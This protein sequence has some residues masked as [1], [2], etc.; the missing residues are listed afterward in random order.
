MIV[1]IGGGAAGFFSAINAAENYPHCRVL[2]FEKS[3]KL[4][5]KVRISGGGRCN[6]THAC[7]DNKLLVKNY[8]RGEKQLKGVFSRFAVKDTI[9]WFANRGVEFHEE[10]DGRM[11]P[12]NNSSETIVNCLTQEAQKKKVDIYCSH[13]LVRIEKRGAENFVL[14]F[15]NGLQY[16]CEAVVVTV[17][18]Q[19]K[20]AKY[21]FI[22]LLGHSI[23]EPIPS[24]FTINLTKNPVTGLM[25]LVAQTARIKI[26]GTNHTCTGPLLITHW[27]F[28]GPAVLRL[29]AFA[30]EHFH[31]CNYQSGILINWIN[32]HEEEVRQ[33]L[34]Q[35]AQERPRALPGNYPLFNLPRRLWEFLLR[36][37]EIMDEKPWAEISKKQLHKL[38]SLLTADEYHMDGKTTFKEEFVTCGGVPLHEVDMRTMQS[39]ICPGLFFAG[40]VLDID[41]I[42]G[43]FNFQAA[44]STA[45][46]AAKNLY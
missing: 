38:I 17:G 8:P 22:R 4:L 39:K 23:K 34:L 3:N 37:A 11:F 26:A 10:E 44:W 33:A 13:E 20:V 14:H 36:K 28:S 24:L 27:G 32:Q 45:W 21:D 6:V 2:L 5:S 1:V 40:E 18:G 16:V 41:G 25:G 42:T 15:A 19:T 35:Y 46:L 12:A 29:S 31:Y 9:A 43:G 30:A 7:F